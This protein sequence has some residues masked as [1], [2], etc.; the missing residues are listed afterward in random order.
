MPIILCC[1]DEKEKGFEGGGE[2][3]PV[4]VR[5]KDFEEYKMRLEFRLKEFEDELRSRLDAL[6]AEVEREAGRTS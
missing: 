6:K 4:F 3:E 5:R 2:S 1:M